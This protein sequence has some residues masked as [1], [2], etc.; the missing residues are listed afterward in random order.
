MFVGPMQI[1]KIDILK[2][3]WN[4][5]DCVEAVKIEMDE[6]IPEGINIGCV[7]V[8]TIKKT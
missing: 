3:Y 2:T 6:G 4:E 5:K 8:G 1:D 7:Y